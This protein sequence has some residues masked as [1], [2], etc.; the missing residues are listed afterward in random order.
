MIL[1]LVHLFVELM[2]IKIIIVKLVKYLIL[3]YIQI[4]IM[5]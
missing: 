4:K 2:I 5:I 3:I 1:N